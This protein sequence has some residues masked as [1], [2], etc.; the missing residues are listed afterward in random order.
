MTQWKDIFCHYV[1]NPVIASYLVQTANSFTTQINMI[2]FGAKY[3]CFSYRNKL[4]P[5]CQAARVLLWL[6]RCSEWLLYGFKREESCDI[7]IL[8]FLQYKSMG[9]FYTHFIAQQ[10]KIVSLIWDELHS[11]V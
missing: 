10:V 3:Q 7:L 9:F 6:L 2:Y 4:L 5:Y 11:K 1:A 8:C